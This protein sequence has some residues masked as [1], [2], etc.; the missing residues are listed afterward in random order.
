MKW[1]ISISRFILGKPN[2][3]LSIGFLVILIIGAFGEIFNWIKIPLSPYLNIVG[4]V[5]A[6]FGFL[7]HVYC[8]RIHKQAHDKSQQINKIVTT[9]IFSKIRH[10]MYLG[11]IATFFGVSIAWGI[12][13]MLIPSVIFSLLTVLIAFKEEEYLQKKFGDQ[14][15]K[16]MQKVCW[17]FI[18]KIF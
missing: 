11:L 13:W 2:I 4:G 18:P 8:H 12:I 7:F 5:V 9:G 14:Y 3:I 1:Q 10:P 17:R 15:R 16:Y 6:A